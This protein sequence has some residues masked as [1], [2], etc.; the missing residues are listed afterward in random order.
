MDI[1][2]LAESLQGHCPA[3]LSLIVYTI[4]YI[5]GGR[6]PLNVLTSSM[7][8]SPRCHDYRKAC[9]R[10]A[11]EARAACSSKTRLLLQ[12]GLQCLSCGE[13]NLTLWSSLRKSRGYYHCSLFCCISIG[14]FS[15][16]SQANSCSVPLFIHEN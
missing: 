4:V 7:L 13:G 6:Q 5:C 1:S 14:A 9:A 2:V 3:P 10:M 16:T 15:G 11:W 12:Q 8:P